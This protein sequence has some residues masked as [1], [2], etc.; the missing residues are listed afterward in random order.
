MLKIVI[1]SF[2]ISRQKSIKLISIYMKHVLLVLVLMEESVVQTY[3]FIVVNALILTLDKIAKKEIVNI[4][5]LFI[6]F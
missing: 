1:I 5:K 6:I 4:N 2:N 3:L